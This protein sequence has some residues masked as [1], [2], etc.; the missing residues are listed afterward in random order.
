MPARNNRGEEQSDDV[1]FPRQRSQTNGRQHNNGRPRNNDHQD[2]NEPGSRNRSDRNRREA[3][4]TIAPKQEEEQDIGLSSIES[5]SPAV[6]I[7]E[8]MTEMRAALSTW[9]DQAEAQRLL[10]HLN[11]L[12][13][14]FE[15]ITPTPE[16]MGADWVESM[17]RWGESGVPNLE[18]VQD[19]VFAG[20]QMQWNRAASLIVGTDLAEESFSTS[21]EKQAAM[22]SYVEYLAK[23][24]HEGSVNIFQEQENGN[25]AGL[26]VELATHLEA[27]STFMQV[28]FG[29]FNEILITE[30]SIWEPGNHSHPDRLRLDALQEH[31]FDVRDQNELTILKSIDACF[32]DVTDAESAYAIA[33]E[34][35]VGAISSYDGWEATVTEAH[36]GNVFYANATVGT[37]KVLAGPSI[38]NRGRE[39]VANP[40]NTHYIKTHKGQ[41][42]IMHADGRKEIRPIEYPAVTLMQKVWLGEYKYGVLAPGEVATQKDYFEL[43]TVAVHDVKLTSADKV[44]DFQDQLT[45]SQRVYIE[46]GNVVRVLEEGVADP[47]DERNLAYR[48]PTFDAQGKPIFLVIDT[49]TKTRLDELCLKAAGSFAK[50]AEEDPRYAVHS[51]EERAKVTHTQL[52]TKEFGYTSWLE[53]SRDARLLDSLAQGLSAENIT[54]RPE[55]ASNVLEARDRYQGMLANFES[56]YLKPSQYL[57]MARERLRA[58]GENLPDYKAALRAE[59]EKIA[60]E[61]AYKAVALRNTALEASRLSSEQGLS[62][63]ARAAFEAFM[64]NID[65]ELEIEFAQL[66]R[67]IPAEVA[68]DEFSPYFRSE[69]V[70]ANVQEYTNLYR[71]VDVLVY[72]TALVERVSSSLDTINHEVRNPSSAGARVLREHAQTPNPTEESALLANAAVMFRRGFDSIGTSGDLTAARDTL[73]FISRASLLTLPQAEEDIDL[74]TEV[75]WEE[76]FRR[77]SSRAL[78]REEI[79]R[80][81]V[82]ENLTPELAQ[83]QQAVLETLAD[84][85]DLSAQVVRVLAIENSLF[86]E[87]GDDAALALLA[88]QVALIKTLACFCV[89][90]DHVLPQSPNQSPT[91]MSLTGFDVPALTTPE[92]SAISTRFQDIFEQ[93]LLAHSSQPLLRRFEN[94]FNGDLDETVPTGPT[95]TSPEDREFSAGQTPPPLNR[96]PGPSANNEIPM[97]SD[98]DATEVPPPLSADMT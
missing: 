13:A 97:V 8:H 29:A 86:E 47:A 91:V 76:N 70:N 66:S 98:D 3:T 78:T 5:A 80:R 59:V 57:A 67:G 2:R 63:E 15:T 54:S 18:E 88:T 51:V 36:E 12:Y 74:G 69:G 25:L 93:E 1:S 68:R 87:T 60:G 72:R 82:R 20:F 17:K 19:T 53:S 77:V 49:K 83:E 46:G 58:Y 45:A 6:I 95:E 85:R 64:A 23:L 4:D 9:S 96:V 84:V 14:H 75:L 37:E 44:A 92:P 94:V 35:Y 90:E 24:A 27:L 62:P 10:T 31:I 81:A 33:T 39:V 61:Y 16:F 28:D 56:T 22:A 89:D 41:T 7:A 34:R 55:F 65:Y 48:V 26:T 21:P 43:K 52:Q 50:L 73:R 11:D 71:Q 38:W 30:P 79:S 42:E 32:T 40:G